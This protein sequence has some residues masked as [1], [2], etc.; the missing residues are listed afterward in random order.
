MSENALTIK[1][2]VGTIALFKK[3]TTGWDTFD[4]IFT[5][6][7][8]CKITIPP[9][10]NQPVAG[11]YFEAPKGKFNQWVLPKG[12]SDGKNV[13]STAKISENGTKIVY[14]AEQK[15]SFN[16]RDDYWKDKARYEEQVR[17]PKIEFQA[18][19]KVILDFYGHCL[20]STGLELEAIDGAID[21][22][23][24]KARAVYQLQQPKAEKKAVASVI[25]AN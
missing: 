6:G 16:G 24:A 22:A 8:E 1:G 10:V 7:E 9:D 25:D 5:N 12:W 20:S 13:S 23:Y 17:D 2:T 15:A 18:Y 19:L 21:E 14:S 4:V 3:G 11:D